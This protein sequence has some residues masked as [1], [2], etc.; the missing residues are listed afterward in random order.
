MMTRSEH[1]KWAKMR[2]L[3]YAESGDLHQA[4]ASMTSDLHKHDETRNPMNDML[5]MIGLQTAVA[6]NQT[7]VINWIKGFTE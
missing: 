6:G 7:A 1:V 2:A 4:V 5:C 3:Q